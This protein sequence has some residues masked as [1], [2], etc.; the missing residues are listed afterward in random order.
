MLKGQLNILLQTQTI[1]ELVNKENVPDSVKTKLLLVQQIREFAI[2]SLGLADTKSY[3][4]VYDQRGEPSIWNVSAC[5]PFEF[6][7]HEWKFPL[8]GSVPYKGFFIKEYADEECFELSNKGLDVRVR[9]AAAWSTLGIM[10]DPVLTNFLAN[11]EGEIAEL[12][13]HEMTHAT[14]W[15]NGGVE[16]NENLA[17]FIGEHGAKAF[18]SHYFGEN[19]RELDAYNNTNEDY[20]RYAN[21]ILGGAYY[22][23]KIYKSMKDKPVTE[24]LKLKK[25]AIHEIIYAI[26]TLNFK[27]PYWKKVK[28][29]LL[30]ELP[31]NAYFMSFMRYREKQASFEEE[32]QKDFKGNIA[33]YIAYLKNFY[34]K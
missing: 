24:K 19:S 27:H 1:Q 9:E 34:G 7:A 14:I 20:L 13:I 21:H 6:K 8:L 12:I 4:S 11:D 2:D 28:P 22:L 25:E 31:N 5:A 10:N 15:V 32:F 23:Q 16:F 29:R 30:Q 17:T 26:D 33:L 3:N 18:L